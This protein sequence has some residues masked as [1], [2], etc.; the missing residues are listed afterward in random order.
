[1]ACVDFD[2]ISA[3]S[4]HGV[5]AR[6]LTQNLDVTVFAHE[7]RREFT[8]SV[9]GSN[10][11]PNNELYA[12]FVY[13]YVNTVCVFALESDYGLPIISTAHS[14][15]TRRQEQDG[16]ASPSAAKNHQQ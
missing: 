4:K 12:L 8:S 2:P 6:Y 11:E 7:R 14:S 16:H 9:H 15:R 10:T 3:T 1:M 13:N 5:Y